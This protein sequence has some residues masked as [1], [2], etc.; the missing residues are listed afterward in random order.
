MSCGST[1]FVWCA[2]VGLYMVCL[3]LCCGVRGAVCMFVVCDMMR[4]V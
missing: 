4:C 3:Y 2:C 1:V